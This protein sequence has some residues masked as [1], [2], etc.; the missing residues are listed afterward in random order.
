[1]ENPTAFL[2][3]YTL[4]LKDR[5]LELN[6]PLVMGIVNL[7]DDSF[8]APSRIKGE[9]AAVERIGEMIMQ[10]ADIIDIGACSSRPG[11]TWVSESEEL[12]RL[13]SVLEK[14]RKTYP[15]AIL[16]IDT[17]RASVAEECISRW[18]V[19]I[20]NDIT[21]GSDVEMYN[22]VARHDA[23]YV[24][25]HMRADSK[26]MDNHCNYEDVVADVIRELAFNID[27][28]QDA[29]VCNLI[30]DPGFGFAK[31]E[32]QNFEMLKHLNYFNVLGYPLLIGISRKRMTRGNNDPD[33][34]EARTATIALNAVALAKGAH[35]IRVHDV[36]EGVI[37]AKTIGKL[38][39]SE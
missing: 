18:K 37:T 16:S 1:M 8:Y 2:Q 17:F 3:P 23:A 28:A 21:G 25:M 38:W 35:I 24:L 20:I 10:G 9:N 6:R 7:T 36:P 34:S 19:D 15:E 5:L 32:E 26:N 4:R 14:I 11:A 31:T 22:V 33:S 39:N 27:K 13:G 12:T 29:G 30:I